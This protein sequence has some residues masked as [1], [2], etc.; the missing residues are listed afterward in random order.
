MRYALKC[1]S[2]IWHDEEILD[3]YPIIHKYN[4]VIDYPYP[5]KNVARIIIEVAD[6][7]DFFY[8]IGYPIILN[9]DVEYSENKLLCLTI[10]DDCL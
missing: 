8:D 2:V 6:L 9:N 1:V 10:Y 5:N 3:K 4:P 7:I